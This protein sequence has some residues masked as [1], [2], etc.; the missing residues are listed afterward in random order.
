[1]VAPRQV[2]M[3]VIVLRLGVRHSEDIMECV[4]ILS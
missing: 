2:S 4:Y 3:D 1:M